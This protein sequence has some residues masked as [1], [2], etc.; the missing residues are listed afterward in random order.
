[1]P[2]GCGAGGACPVPEDQQDLAKPGCSRTLFSRG[3]ATGPLGIRGINMLGPMHWL[4]SGAFPLH[5]GA[6]VASCAR[7]ISWE[8]QQ[9]GEK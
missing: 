3:L 5:Q 1:M 4:V 9:T 2:A 6:A 8:R 7:N